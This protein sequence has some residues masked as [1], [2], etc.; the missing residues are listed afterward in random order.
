MQRDFGLY[1]AA[2]HGI[3]DEPLPP[4]LPTYQPLRRALPHGHSV[5]WDPS[6][7]SASG[8]LFALGGGGGIPDTPGGVGYVSGVLGAAGRAGADGVSGLSGDALWGAAS[9]TGAGRSWD[10]LGALA[11]IR[12]SLG[13]SVSAGG[14]SLRD[15]VVSST[16]GAVSTGALADAVDQPFAKKDKVKLRKDQVRRHHSCSN[17]ASPRANVVLY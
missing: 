13:G 11:A 14:G 1:V 15:R 16:A 10:G 6:A 3:Q 17:V 2:R 9:P 7:L 8:G 5:M 12:D 4:S